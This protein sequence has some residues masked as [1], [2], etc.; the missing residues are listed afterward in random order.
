MIVGCHSR[1]AMQVVGEKNTLTVP[2]ANVVERPTPGDI[3]DFVA[4]P[5]PQ[6]PLDTFNNFKITQE[7]MEVI[8]KEYSTVDR[9]HW[10]HGYSHVGFGVRTGYLILK[11]GEKIKWMVKPAGLATLEFQNGTMLYL[12]GVK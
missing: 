2:A 4:D 12:A 11:D 9:E 6:A 1:P 3:R 10:L 7:S 8:L 5:I